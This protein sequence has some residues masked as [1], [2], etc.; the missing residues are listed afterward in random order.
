MAV[1][2][3]TTPKGGLVSGFLTWGMFWFVIATVAAGFF[4]ADGVDALA[5]AWR[6]PEYSHGL[7]I[8]V[9]SLFLFLRDLKSVPENPGPVTD[10]GVGI[11]VVL[12]AFA[13]AAIG[14]LAN[15]SDIVTYAMIVW[16]G[17]MILISFGWKTGRVFWP[18]VLHL[19]Y[20]L[21]LP[22]TFYYKMTNS[23]QL[24]SSEL[25]VF[26]LKVLNVPVFL[27]GNI[28]DLGVLQLHVADACSGLQYLF[29]ILS[30]SYIFAVLYR[31]SVW[32][33]AVL[34]LAAVPI[35]IFMNSVRIALAGVIANTYGVEWLDGFTHFFEG[36]VIFMA[37]IAILFLMAWAMLKLQRSP[38]SLVEALDL[39]TEGLGHPGH[40]AASDPALQGPDRG[41]CHRAQRP[42]GLAIR[43]RTRRRNH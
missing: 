39:E 30:F 23:L 13:M 5:Y 11:G 36:W 9:L 40:A 3:D 4:F 21:P 42:G 29:P 18:A 6:T 35:T 16:V 38:M 7:L 32:H 41:G 31:G 24:I 19:V 14:K 15:I 12:L 10:R 17:G 27:Q 2:S 33:K 37:C 43:P 25:G 28:I 1:T 20:M 34:L 26:F 22:D 8:P